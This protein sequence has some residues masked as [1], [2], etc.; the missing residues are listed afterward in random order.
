MIL[1]AATSTT[2]LSGPTPLVALMSFPARLLLCSILSI[3]SSDRDTHYVHRAG[4]EALGDT[5]VGQQCAGTLSTMVNLRCRLSGA[6]LFVLGTLTGT[7][8]GW[9]IAPAKEDDQG[10]QR[11]CEKVI[12]PK[13]QGSSARIGW[14]VSGIWTGF[15][16]KLDQSSLCPVGH[17]DSNGA[18]LM[19]AH[20]YHVHPVSP[21]SITH[22]SGSL[23]PVVFCFVSNVNSFN[24]SR[25]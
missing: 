24:G 21:T 15:I 3:P 6:G 1:P 2:H 10:M 18:V 22:L 16:L 20:P 17:T 7:T 4:C 9:H 19:S 5:V 25:I 13:Y 23:P 11:R 8:Q 12:L 14:F